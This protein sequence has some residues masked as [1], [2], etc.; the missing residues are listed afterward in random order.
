MAYSKGVRLMEV[1]FGSMIRQIAGD[2]TEERI[3]GEVL[4]DGGDGMI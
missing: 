3:K 2:W 1:L 4:Q